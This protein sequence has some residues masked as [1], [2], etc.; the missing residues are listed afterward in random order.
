M[1]SSVDD[2]IKGPDTTTDVT[3]SS[4]LT[5][6]DLPPGWKPVEKSPTSRTTLILA[7]SLV[8]AF[9][10]CST[11]LGCLFWRK[12]VQKSA[13]DPERGRKKKKRA[14]E[15]DGEALVVEKE[16]KVKQKIWARATARWKANVRQSA[17]QRRRISRIAQANQ[18]SV[19]FDNSRS[20]LAPSLTQS[21]SSSRSST[22]RVPVHQRPIDHSEG[23]LHPISSELSIQDTPALAQPPA[24]Q[25]RGLLPASD[26]MSAQMYS[27]LTP[28]SVHDRSRRPSH[29]SS[30]EA[31]GLNGEHAAAALFS[32]HVATDDK[33]F[34]ARLANM[35]SAPPS[36]ESLVPGDLPG[37]VH[38]SVPTWHDEDIDDFDACLAPP[39]SHPSAES[40]LSAPMFPPP[41]SKERLIAAE[42]FEYSYTLND[43]E[44]PELEPSEPSAPPFEESLAPLAP[45]APP[46]L[47]DGDAD[48]QPSAPQWDSLSL[49]QMSEETPSGQDY[50]RI[51]TTNVPSPMLNSTMPA[52]ATVP[53]PRDSIVLPVY[54]P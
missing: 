48:P 19:S 18:S 43:L 53:S 28:P 50:D 13:K 21:R 12:K 54:R 9:V 23:P 16:V 4:K 22:D 32:A 17:R 38:A 11:I 25:H 26:N 33:Q 6:D 14:K 27:G 7:V 30:A 15:E 3:A 44:T 10:I 31:S 1:P 20:Y 37:S 51:P 35:A 2:Q 8:L 29:S 45:S 24:Y 49:D 41:P 39:E 42:A 40:S 47:E 5:V 52:T 36:D 46:L 34:L